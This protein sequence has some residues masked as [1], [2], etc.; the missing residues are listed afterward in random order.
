M[1]RATWKSKH[2]WNLSVN[3]L[4]CNSLKSIC[5]KWWSF[6]LPPLRG[7]AD[8]QRVPALAERSALKKRK[9]KKSLQWLTGRKV[10]LTLSLQLWWVVRDKLLPVT[11]PKRPSFAF[12]ILPC[13]A[14][15]SE[16]SNPEE[17]RRGGLFVRFGLLF[18]SWRCVSSFLRG[19]LVQFLKC[20]ELAGGFLEK[21]LEGSRELTSAVLAARRKHLKILVR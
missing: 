14:N 18:C 2:T 12:E 1:W 21:I 5:S 9:E 6:S 15:P 10:G 11:F 7:C 8:E 19:H 20:H 4:A 17:R 13:S 3:H 16:R